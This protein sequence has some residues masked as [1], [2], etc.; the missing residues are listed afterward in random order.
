MG[1]V[2]GVGRV[3]CRLHLFRR[4][5]PPKYLGRTSF[6]HLVDEVLRAMDADVIVDELRA[7][8]LRAVA[9]Q[10]LRDSRPPPGSYSGY[11]PGPRRCYRSCRGRRWRPARIW[12]RALMWPWAE[13]GREA[14]RVAGDGRLTRQIEA[15][16]W[17]PGWCT[18][19]KAQLGQEGVPERQQLIEV[20]AQRA[21]RWCRACRVTGLVAQPEAAAYRRRGCRLRCPRSCRSRACRSGCREMKLSAIGKGVDGELAVVAAAG[22]SLTLTDF[23]R[24][25][26]A[27]R[28]GSVRCGA[29]SC[30]SCSSGASR[31]AP[32]RK[33]PSGPRCRGG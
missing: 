2:L 28:P 24:E 12:L 31:T 10:H 30:R 7:L 5:M 20:Q 1:L 27:A 16:G 33:R 19:G 18:T 13:L 6:G 8:Q 17:T 22:R 14:G 11:P 4:E 23:L 29:V 25:V 3:G 21:C 15:A 9:C 32:R 26:L